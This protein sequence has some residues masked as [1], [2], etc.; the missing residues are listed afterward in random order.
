MDARARLR[1]YLEQRREL[2]ETELVLDTLPVEDVMAM[3]GAR[4]R[5]TRQ[6]PARQQPTATPSQVAAESQRPAPVAPPPPQR[7]TGTVAETRNW[8]SVLATEQP[9]PLAGA[10]VPAAHAPEWLSAL[11]IPFGERAGTDSLRARATLLDAHIASLPSLDAIAETTASCQRCSLHKSALRAVPGEGNPNADFVCVGEAPG[12]TEDEQGRPFVGAAGQLLN[13]ILGAINF[14]RDDVFI[15]NVMKH[16][17]PGNR[18]PSPDEVS[19]CAPYLLRQLDLLQPK[20]ILALGTFAARTLLGVDISIS[21]L[22]G[23]I[24]FFHGVPVVVTYHPAA[25]LR[26]ESWKRPTWDD[27][28]LA[29][30]IYDASRAAV[31]PT[32]VVDAS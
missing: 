23:R 8:R 4:S 9:S 28:K 7:R 27:V 13:K 18:D 15:C 10:T 2:G 19:A 29:R 30:L 31:A 6:P 20:V 22:R 3:L 26:N 14:A 1:R 25:L 5:A 17:P 12:Q 21:K 24:H 16:R 11:G 32:S